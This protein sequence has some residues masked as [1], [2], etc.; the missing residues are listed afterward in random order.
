[1]NQNKDLVKQLYEKLFNEEIHCDNVYTSLEKYI[2]EQPATL[3]VLYAL[4]DS[5]VYLYRNKL[6]NYYYSISKLKMKYTKI[7]RNENID[8]PLQQIQVIDMGWDIIYAV[9]EFYKNENPEVNDRDIVL[10][11]LINLSTTMFEKKIVPYCY[12]YSL[13]KTAYIINKMKEY[14]S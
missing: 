5:S 3:D 7:N 2:D 9:L 13:S 11:S 14:Y 8:P 1:M 4:S 6:L 10:K 12:C